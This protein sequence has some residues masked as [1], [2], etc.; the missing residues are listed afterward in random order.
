MIGK[1]TKAYF[2]AKTPYQRLIESTYLDSEQMAMLE[3][4]YNN[5]NPVKLMI[6]LKLGRNELEQTL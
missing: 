2:E 5:L 1:A 4:E 3:S 6:E